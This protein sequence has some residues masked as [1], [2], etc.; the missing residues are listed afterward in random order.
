MY[1]CIY[2]SM[3]LCIYVSMYLCIYVCM[4]LCMFTYVI[5]CIHIQ[6]IKTIR[7]CNLYIRAQ[8]QHEKWEDGRRKHN[9][10]QY[11][12][13]TLSMSRPLP[14]LIWSNIILSTLDQNGG[15]R[16]ATVTQ[17]RSYVIIQ[18]R[19]LLGFENNIPQISSP[20]FA[21]AILCLV[22]TG[23]LAWFSTTVPTRNTD[24]NTNTATT[25]II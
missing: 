9:T 5:M 25:I 15:G 23:T 16:T 24:K 18:V 17:S 6:Y 20:C 1:L 2:V 14:L 13:E 19:S 10:W 21:T 22:S 7:S 8:S 11:I 4:Y 3:Y 12:C